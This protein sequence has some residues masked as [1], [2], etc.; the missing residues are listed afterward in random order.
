MKSLIRE[1]VYFSVYI[2]ISI[3]AIFTMTSMV[4]HAQEVIVI[5][6]IQGKSDRH[7]Y[8]QELLIEVLDSTIASHG[9]YQIKILPHLSQ[10][11]TASMLRR[12]E[13]YGD[14]VQGA[15]RDD[16]E[17]HLIPIKIPIMK[18]TIGLRVLLIRQDKQPVFSAITSLEQLK[19]QFGAVTEYWSITK[20]FEY[21]KFNVVETNRQDSMFAM[22]EKQR[23]DYISRGINE[24][25][26]EYTKY[27]PKNPNLH[28]E[29]SLLINIPLPVYFFVNPNKSELAERIT[30]G[31]NN[32][33]NNGVL[34]KL[35]TKHFKQQFEQLNLF[36]RK[37]FKLENPTLT[38]PYHSYDP[39]ELKALFVDK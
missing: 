34:D 33:L 18:G 8:S 30:V 2:H 4:I 5:N 25:L 24:V 16:W 3:L 29:D 19:Q 13:G 7:K 15:L 28:I 38:S 9:D 1:T 21:H 10:P 23:F 36:N 37:L 6:E 11:R 22:L 39:D 26:M 27:Q 14:I 35:F 20:V 17:E 12:R 31:L 32:V